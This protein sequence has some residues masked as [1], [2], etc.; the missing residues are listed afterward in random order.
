[1]LNN[2]FID[3]TMGYIKSIEQQLYTLEKEKDSLLEEVEDLVSENKTLTKRVKELEKENDELKTEKIVNNSLLR[4]SLKMIN[5]ANEKLINANHQVR[6]HNFKS[7][8]RSRLEEL[9]K[10]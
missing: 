2:A 10:T 3:K 9:N 8:M 4:E 6:V 1:M 7:F 5:K